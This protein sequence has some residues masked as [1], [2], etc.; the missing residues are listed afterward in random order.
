[1]NNETKRETSVHSISTREVPSS[2]ILHFKVGRY[3]RDANG[4]SHTASR[5]KSYGKM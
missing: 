1:M 5:S 3:I 4:T 2:C